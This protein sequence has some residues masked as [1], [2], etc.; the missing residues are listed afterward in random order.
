[1]LLSNYIYISDG[2]FAEI[3][4]IQDRLSGRKRQEVLN[5]LLYLCGRKEM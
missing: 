5:Y 2:V 4:E 3:V 1:M